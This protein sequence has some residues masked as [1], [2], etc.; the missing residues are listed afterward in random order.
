M[1]KELEIIVPP[2]YLN[3]KDYLCNSAAQSLKINPFEITAVVPVRRSIDSRSRRPV[4]RILCNV[5]INEYQLTEERVIHYKPVKSNRK[6]LIIGCGPGGM[7]VA[8]RLIELGI[9]L[10]WFSGKWNFGLIK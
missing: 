6:V 5:F 1:K 8:L 3:D 2:E 9:K 10:Y 7:F 4:F